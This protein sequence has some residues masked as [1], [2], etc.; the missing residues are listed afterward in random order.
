[1]GDW[2]L[3]GVL[4]LASRFGRQ[5]NLCLESV[6]LT[7]RSSSMVLQAVTSTKTSNTFRLKKKKNCKQNKLRNRR[8]PTTA[9]HAD[10][11]V[12]WR[13]IPMRAIG[14]WTTLGELVYPSLGYTRSNPSWEKQHNT[15]RWGP[16][17]FQITPPANRTVWYGV[18]SVVHHPSMNTSS[19]VRFSPGPFWFSPRKGEIA[20]RVPPRSSLLFTPSIQSSVSTWNIHLRI[21]EGQPPGLKSTT[22]Q[23]KLEETIKI[24]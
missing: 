9:N 5:A 11:F 24:C 1:M 10:L 22:P 23:H 14:G 6:Q 12:S 4:A 15:W 3:T 19:P 16:V 8:M 13:V 21:S 2:P 7:D 20:P 17:N 18:V